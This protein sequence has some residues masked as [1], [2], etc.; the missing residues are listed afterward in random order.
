MKNKTK[1]FVQ[2]NFCLLL[3]FALFCSMPQTNAQTP[4]PNRTSPKTTITEGYTLID[5]DIQMPTEF[6]KR[7]L[8]KQKQSPNR[9]EAVVDADSWTNGIIP[10]EF[11]DNVTA[12]NQSAMIS[13]MAVL[14]SAANISFQQCFGN[15]CHPLSNHVHVQNSTVNNSAVGMRG[16]EQ[17][18]NITSWN[19]QFIIVH[20]LM[21]CLGFYHEQARADRN[22]FVQ[23]NCNNVQGGCSGTLF[24]SN[25]VI[26]DRG[27]AFGYYDFDSVMHYS[28]CTFS[29]DCPAGATCNCTN[30]VITVLPPNQSQQT[31]IGQRTHLSTLDRAT[32]SFLYPYDNWRF[33]D[34]NHDD[35][36]FTI[37]FGTFLFPYNNPVNA[38]NNTPAGGTLWVLDNCSFPVRTYNQQVTVKAA[39]GVTARFG[40]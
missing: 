23:I 8:G 20:E 30:T 16:L 1:S 38:L 7:I 13:A 34:C 24:N 31:L 18:I 35:G 19:N 10:F 5:G 17:I 11:D 32:V 25:F 28:Q 22:T 14:E 39:P 27:N 37:Q 9:P 12:A 21:H 15:L 4:K 33:Y 6:V 40:N 3:L 26:E 2:T 36:I 29:I